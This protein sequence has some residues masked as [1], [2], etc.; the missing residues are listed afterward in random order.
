MMKLRSFGHEAEAES[1]GFNSL[2]IHPD[3]Y[4]NALLSGMRAIHQVLPAIMRKLGIDKDFELD[5]SE[6][7]AR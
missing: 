1:L 3:I 4:M 5:E 2:H 6:F 7:R